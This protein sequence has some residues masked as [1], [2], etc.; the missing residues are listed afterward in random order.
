MDWS[1]ESNDARLQGLGSGTGYHS[2]ELSKARNT[3]KPIDQFLLIFVDER[4][5]SSSST[6]LPRLEMCVQ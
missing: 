6:T 1:L 4:R 3:P 2:G 5:S